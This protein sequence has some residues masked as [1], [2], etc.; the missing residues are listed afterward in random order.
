MLWVS[1][2]VGLLLG[3]ASAMWI[4]IKG[5]SR[6]IAEL[7]AVM[8]AFAGGPFVFNLGHGLIQQTP[9]A[10]VEQMLKRVRGA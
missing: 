7:K 5:L 9:L 10:N 1:A 2:G 8:E 6:P 3:L 4:G